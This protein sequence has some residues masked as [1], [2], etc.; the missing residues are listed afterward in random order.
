MGV[1]SAFTY[2][3]SYGVILGE[4]ERLVKEHSLFGSFVSPMTWKTQFNLIKKPKSESIKRVRQLFKDAEPGLL[5]GLTSHGADSV[6]I[7]LSRVK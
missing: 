6:L 5:K 7:G 1:V 4:V 3:V 2:G